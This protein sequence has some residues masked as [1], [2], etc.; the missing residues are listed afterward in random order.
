[1][2]LEYFTEN[3]VNQVIKKYEILIGRE[4]HFDES[5]TRCKLFDIVKGTSKYAGGFLV[6][7]QSKKN[8]FINICDFMRLNKLEYNFHAFETIAIEEAW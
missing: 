1:M 2:K 8:A 4:F 5:S 6:L 3:G 7:F